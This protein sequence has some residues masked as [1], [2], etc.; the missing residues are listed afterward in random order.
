MKIYIIIDMEGITG[1]VSPDKQAKPGSPGYEEAREFLMSD[2]NA[3]VQGTLEGGASEVLIYDMH[4]YGLNVI[5][6]KLHPKAK[7]I[8]GNPHVVSPEMGL[9]N[10]FKGML[11]IG[12]HAMAETEG[13]LLPHTYSYDMKALYLNGVLMGEIGMEASIAGT[14]GI[15]LVMLSGD[16][17]GIEEGKK[18]VEDFEEATVKY[19]IDD[20]GAV[21]LPLSISRKIIKEKALSAVK[22]INDFKPYSPPNLND[23]EYAYLIELE[24]YEANF[25]DKALAAV[26][27]IDKEII[28]W[29]KKMSEKKIALKG[30]NL[31]LLWKGFTKRYQG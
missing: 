30:N 6:D 5:L 12:F 31:P 9:N 28:P 22:G 18:I 19:A 7:I 1:V 15:P 17:K 21:C 4:Y 26:K 23:P 29:A 8:M 3:T 14:Y 27:K 25:V 20:E 16:S 11:M 13:A 24:F 2:L 10:T